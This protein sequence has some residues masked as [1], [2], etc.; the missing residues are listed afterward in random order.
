[1]AILKKYLASDFFLW[2][3]W[4]G[5]IFLFVNSGTLV[6]DSNWGKF[7][8]NITENSS[9]YD[10][11][12]L[13]PYHNKFIFGFDAIFVEY[14]HHIDELDWRDV[15]DT[16]LFVVFLPLA[17]I[18]FFCIFVREFLQLKIDW[19]YYVKSS[20]TLWKWVFCLELLFI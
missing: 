2:N 4:F 14:W 13:I 3:F 16:Y 9:N 20:E 18:G 7:T 12:F 15:L 10:H 1:M 11:N 5:I 6:C 8:P 19:K 17:L